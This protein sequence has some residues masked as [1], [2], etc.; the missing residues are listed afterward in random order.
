M[1]EPNL[2]ALARNWRR[3]ECRLPR[4]FLDFNTTRRPKAAAGLTPQVGFIPTE[5]IERKKGQVSESQKATRE[6]YRGGAGI[7]LRV[8]YPVHQTYAAV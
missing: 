2:F 7:L 4:S 3:L 8:G 5:T 1:I 6:L